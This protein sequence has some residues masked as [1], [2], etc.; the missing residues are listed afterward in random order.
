KTPS[1]VAVINATTD[2]VYA[3]RPDAQPYK[4]D[5]PLGG[6]DPY[7]TSKACAELVTESYRKSF[8][9]NGPCVATARAGN[10]I[11][12]GDWA[13]DRLVP[14]MVRAMASGTPIVLR[15][16]R[17]V[18]PWQHVLEPLSGYLRLG[19]AML[20]GSV[21]HAAWNFGPSN[22]ADLPVSSVIAALHGYWP[23]VTVMEATDPQPHE[24]SILRLDGARAEHELGWRAVWHA[25]ETLRRTAGWYNAWYDSQ[26]LST[27]S[28]LAGYVADAQLRGD[29]WAA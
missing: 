5:D 7:S 20:S 19:Q 2:K 9:Q 11:G 26:Q 21:K 28:D 14:D 10:V 25:D 13:D 27:S 29:V 3:A 23:A 12:G 4:E 6:H 18:R 22:D 17:A 8:F 24:A 15:N 1:V 16:P